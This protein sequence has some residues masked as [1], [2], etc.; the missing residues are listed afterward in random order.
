MLGGACYIFAALASPGVINHTGGPGRVVFGELDGRITPRAHAIR[1][2]FAATG[3]PVELSAQILAAMWEKYLFITG[4]G[5]MTALTRLPIGIIRATPAT[6]EM[7]LDV[8]S[9]VASVGRAHGVSIPEGERD[10]VKRG[11]DSLSPNSFSSLYNDLVGGRRMELETLPG[12]VVRLG[13]QYRIPTP[14]C[15]AIYAAL[16]PYDE[17]AQRGEPLAGKE[18]S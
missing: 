17:A 12:H 13:R 11:A 9:E 8:A 18:R 16:K 15:R 10:R 7:Y 2:A 14:V 6:M 1:D 5:G 4:Q 3:A